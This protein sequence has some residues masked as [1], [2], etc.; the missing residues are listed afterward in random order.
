MAKKMDATSY[1]RHRQTA[2][3]L[4]RAVCDALTPIFE[5]RGSISREELERA[6]ACLAGMRSNTALLFERNCRACLANGE[7][8]TMTAPARRPVERRHDFATRLLFSHVIETV[9]ERLDPLTGALYP[10]LLAPALQSVVSGLFFDIE[11]QALNAE[12]QAAFTKIGEISDHDVRK[13]IDADPT[14]PALAGAVFVR[15][16]LRFRQFTYQRQTFTKKMAELLRP[17][18]FVFTEEHF[19]E[20]FDAIARGVPTDLDCELGSIQTDI[21][22]GEGTASELVRIL[23]EFT[24]YRESLGDRKKGPPFRPLGVSRRLISANSR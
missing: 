19:V 15:F 7:A 14:L 11:W 24:S 17:C 12:A 1:D 16:I 9:P 18:R 10:R 8:H 6:V 21:R 2:E 20:L 4:L 5:T 23:G 22:F 13:R 3:A